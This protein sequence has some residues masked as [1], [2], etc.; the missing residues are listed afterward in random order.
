MNSQGSLTKTGEPV[1]ENDVMM[2]IKQSNQCRSRL[3]FFF[4]LKNIYI[5]ILQ[6]AVFPDL[7]KI[8]KASCKLNSLIYFRFINYILFN[9]QL[10]I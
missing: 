1:K 5:C 8:N 7:P 6:L 10:I 2:N 3:F 4:A 9:F